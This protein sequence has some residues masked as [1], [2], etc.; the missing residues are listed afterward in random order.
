MSIHHKPDQSFDSIA[1]KFQRNIYGTTKGRLRHELLMHYLTPFIERSSM[2]ILEAGGGSGEMAEELLKLGHRVHVIDISSD[3]IELAKKRCARYPGF[4]CEVNE[5]QQHD[6]PEKYDFIL[7]HAVM[8]WLTD[9]LSIIP[10]LISL[11]GQHGHL[12]L[13]FFNKDAHLFG[14]VLYGNFDYIA[15]GFN[16]PN[17]VRLNPNNAVK[18]QD[19][20]DCLGELQLNVV[21]KAGL[22]CFHDYVRD[23][24]IQQS[25]YQ[26]LKEMELEY[27]TQAP[28]MWLG[29]YFH[30]IAQNPAA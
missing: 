29:K 27:G 9:P 12:S 7:C 18:P 11:L 2:R 28:F 5:I 19:V 10:S 4:S 8:E 22:R 23:K 30:L 20:I 6:S 13:S 14:N 26:Q 21:H 16:V 1:D 3:M 17:R 24:T 15:K 25:H